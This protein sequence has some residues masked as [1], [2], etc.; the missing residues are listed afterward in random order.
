MIQAYLTTLNKRFKSG[1][2][3][4]HTYRGDLENLIRE[5]SPQVDITNE[6]SHVT[7]CGNPDFVITKGKIPIGYIEAKDIDKDLNAKQ[8]KEQFTRYKE[9]LDNL[10]ITN[11]TWFQFYQNG[12]LQHEIR[13]AEIDGNKIN[14][15]PENFAEF[16][17]LIQNFC[18]FIGQT[19]KSSKK[20]AKMMASK[21]LLLQNILTKAITSDEETQENTQLQEQYESFKKI[22]IHDLKPKDFADIYAQTLAYGMFAA[23]LHDPTLDD[24]SRQEAAELIPKSNPFLRR[25]F[26]YIAG[27]DIDER[28]KSIVDNLADVFRATD[29]DA[30]LH[31][32]GKSTQTQDPIIHFYETFLAEYD[33]KLRKSRGVWY[34][35]EPVVNFI[36]RAVDD[37]LKTEFNLS[38][39]L[40][41]TSKIKIKVETDI[42][43]KRKGEYKKE[44]KEVHKV[45]ILDPAAGTGTFLAEV[46][47]NIYNQY[48]QNMQGAWSEY[49]DEHLIPRLNGFELLM[50]SYTMA[51]LKLDMLLSETGYKPKQEKRFHIYLT[52][53]LEEYH[54][55]TGTLFASWLSNESHEANHI[56]RDTPV[57][58]VLGNPPYSG[59]SANKGEWISNLMDDYKKE[60]G[61]KVKLKERNSKWI[62]DDYVKFL[63]YGQY[64]IKK[65]GEGILAF[66]NAHGFLD[67][68]TF[69][70]M[71][72]NLLKTYD[73]IYILDLHGNSK[74]KEICPDGSKDE[75]VFDIQQGVSINIFIKTGRKRNSEL[76]SIFHYDLYGLREFKYDFFL[77]HNISDIS[78]SEIQNVE[79]DYFFVEKDFDAQVQYQLGFKINDLFQLNS[80]GIVTSRDNFVIG[81]SIEHLKNKIND[82]IILDKEHLKNKYHLKENLRW[83][84]DD[85]KGKIDELNSN[86]IYK[87]SYRPFDN[88][89]LYYDND[90]IE[91]GRKGVM[92]HFINVENIGLVASKQCV[93]DWRYVFLTKFIGEFNL[94]GTAG[95]FGS[96]YYFPLYLYLDKSEQNLIDDN[97]DRTPN[98]NPEIVQEIAGKLHL[99]FTSE[100]DTSTSLS[101]TNS[102]APVDILDYIYAVLHSPTYRE[103]YKEFLKIDF[104]RVPYPK[105]PATFWK[106]VKLGGEL[107]QIHLLESPKVEEYITTYPVDGDNVI[108][109]RITKKDWEITNPAKQLGRI[110]INDTQY[111]DKIPLVAWE[112]YI[113][114]YQPAHKWLKDRRGRKLSFEDILH[115]QKIVVALAETDRLMKEIDKIEIE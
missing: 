21:A 24:F 94:T 29:V 115:Y 110:W 57:M 12:K 93:S 34:T 95:R 14:P 105:D 7:D 88:K 102:F 67:N 89:F 75:N 108:T 97:K 107:R 78:Y 59:E 55:D 31:N 65:N 33:P 100:K 106:L 11:Y 66:V 58:V 61:G 98:L 114:G 112:F 38:K 32:F 72:W 113:G 26:Q 40:A 25:L 109:R 17:N 90:F 92:K 96:G 104:P 4:E 81:E 6:P 99:T 47:R 69:R 76:G 16:E 2:S 23:R 19:I 77:K 36:V 91:R 103:K 1:I 64:Y 54:P 18:T 5:L 13:I 111:F 46:V 27:Y 86:L 41:D 39:G 22:L 83:K 60:P 10:I 44:E 8:Y 43:D 15:L 49:V 45:Q 63:R 71:R 56:K 85:V 53:S 35:P 74:K 50:A 48:F 62:N 79:P 82:F 37:I 68:P 101:V 9:A 80:V 30:L 73:K 70:G 84:I 51:H 28:I 87:I 20:L 42:I 3:S 52:N